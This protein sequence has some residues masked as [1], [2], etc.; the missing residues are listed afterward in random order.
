MVLEHLQDQEATRQA[1]LEYLQAQEDHL[2]LDI[3]PEEDLQ[4]QLD[5]QSRLLIL[6]QVR[7]IIFLTFCL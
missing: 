3:L 2:D 1:E 5:L 7:G 6:I 4:D